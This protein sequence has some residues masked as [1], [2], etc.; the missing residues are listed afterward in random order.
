M[1]RPTNRQEKSTNAS[2]ISALSV[3]YHPFAL[4]GARSTRGST[5]TPGIPCGLSSPLLLT[6]TPTLFPLTVTLHAKVIDSGHI[7]EQQAKHLGSDTRVDYK[8][9]TNL[10]ELGAV[11]QQ[12]YGLDREV[13]HALIGKYIYFRYLRDREILDD[14]WLGEHNIHSED[15]FE[16]T[17]T[18][19]GF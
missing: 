17:A 2:G 5:T 3:C 9:L 7:W 6:R 8:L 16:R 1:P 12:S 15:I 10:E 19:K 4:G 13:A 11:L 14:A 18:A